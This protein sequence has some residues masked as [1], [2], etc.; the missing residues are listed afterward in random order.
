MRVHTKDEV[1]MLVIL[2]IVAP[3]IAVMTDVNQARSL[4]AQACGVGRK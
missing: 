3:I 4:R 2:V 1:L